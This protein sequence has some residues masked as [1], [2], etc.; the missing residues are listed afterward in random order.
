MRSLLP[1]LAAELST[2]ERTLRRAVRRGAVRCRRDGPRQLAL[3]DG[4]R[5]YLR[6][7]W[8]TL[9][10]LTKT[11]R[12]ESNVRLAVLYGSV[13]RGDD[14][15]TSD[16]DLL[17][18]LRKGTGH[19]ALG[20]ADRL[21]RRLGRSVDVARLPLVRDASP[22]LLLQ[23]LDEGRVLVDRDDGWTALRTERDAIETAAALAGED[24]AYAAG[25]ALE[26]LLDAQT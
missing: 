7:H 23:A 3:G 1:T 25:S 13:A 20:L 18:D 14:G 5:S 11:L 16:I 2:D 17:V 4:E 21:E 6:T 24:E 12:T 8:S 10:S 22:L 19:A 9:S 26:E 15:P